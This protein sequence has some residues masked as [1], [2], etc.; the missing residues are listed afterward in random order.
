[1]ASR[2]LIIFLGC[3]GSRTRGKNLLEKLNPHVPSKGF[4]W[5]EMHGG[6]VHAAT[7]SQLRIARA[8]KCSC[9]GVVLS[10]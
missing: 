8:G 6:E 2:A 5:M 9:G 1:M 7:R 3:W 10:C 4:R